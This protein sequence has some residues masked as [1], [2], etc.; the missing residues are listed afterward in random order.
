MNAFTS[1]DFI[2]FV[3]SKLDE[4]GIKKLIPEGETLE[5]AYRRACQIQ[6]VNDKIEE[7]ADL[8]RGA[9]GKEKE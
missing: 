8:V 4:Q 6:F 3:E 7:V 5:L 2:E 1:S 9:Y